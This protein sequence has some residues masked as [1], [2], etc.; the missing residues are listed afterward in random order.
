MIVNPQQSLT[1]LLRGTGDLISVN[2]PPIVDVEQLY[3]GHLI[4]QN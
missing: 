4:F 2:H 1:G 3:T